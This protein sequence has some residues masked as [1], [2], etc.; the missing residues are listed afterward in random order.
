MNRT[1]ELFRIPRNDFYAIVRWMKS[2]GEPTPEEW[3]VIF[4]LQNEIHEGFAD[5]LRREAL[6]A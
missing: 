3:S 4:R 6:T 2:F 1:I 5:R